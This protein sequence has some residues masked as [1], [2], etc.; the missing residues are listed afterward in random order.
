MLTAFAQNHFLPIWCC[1]IC[2][3]WAP[4]AFVYLHLCYSEEPRWESPISFQMLLLGP[5][6]TWKTTWGLSSGG[7]KWGWMWILRKDLYF[8]CLLHRP[9]K[10]LLQNLEI[11]SKDLCK[12]NASLIWA[13][14]WPQKGH[15]KHFSR[16]TIF[17]EHP[18]WIVNFRNIVEVEISLWLHFNMCEV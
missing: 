1:D 12:E 3:S 15:V 5:W 17:M 18:R 2:H 10:C 6:G 13:R 14:E 4:S 9:L 7:G 11:L 8:L 16:Q